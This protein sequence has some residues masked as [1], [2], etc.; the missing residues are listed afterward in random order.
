MTQPELTVILTHEHTDFDALASLLAASLLFPGALPVLPGQ[1]N[2]NVR[3]FLA[4]YKNQFPFYQAKELP[5]VAINHLIV[6]DTRSANLPKGVRNDA[7]WLVIDHHRTAPA[8][9]EARSATAHSEL[10]HAAVGANTT[11]L[12]EKLVEQHIDLTPAQVTLLALGIH[13]DTGSLTY[14]A[15]THRDG[16]ALAWLMEPERGLNLEV[17]RQF[18]RHPLSEAQRALLETLIDQSEFFEMAGH[19]VVIASAQAPDFT[20]EL[21]TLAHRLRDIHE[22][23]AIFLVVGLGEMVQVVA[24]STTDGLDVG[25]I[26]RGLGGGGHARAAAAPVHHADLEAVRNQISALLATHSQPAVTVRHIMT[27]GRP[28]LFSPELTIHEAYELMRRYGHEGYPVVAQTVEGGE[29]LLGVITRREVD[30]AMNHGLTERRVRS[31]M[32]PG[33]ITVRAYDSIAILRKTMIESGWG[34]VPVVDEAGKIIGIVTRTDLIKLWDEHTPPERHASEIDQRLRATLSSAQIALLKL[35]GQEVDQMDF[36]VY[37]VGGFVRD[38]LLNGAN[39]RNGALDIDIVIE[40]DAAAFA[41]RMQ[42]R[43]GGR[44]VIHKRFG[45]AKWLLNDP[46][47]PVDWRTLCAA[48]VLEDGA[49]QIASQLPAHLDFVTART[50]FYTAPTVL[51][52]VELSNIKLDL[53]RRDFTINTLACCLNPD[54]WGE[55]LDFYGGLPDLRNGLVRVLHSLSFVDDPTRIL[56][57]VRYEQRFGFQIEARTE[58][59][60]QD[61][62]ELLERVTPARIRH[63][64]E[65]ILQEAAPERVLQR[66]AQLGGLA[67]IHPALRVDEWVNVQFSRLRT[68]LEQPTANPSL[69]QAPLDLLYWGLLTLRLPSQAHTDLTVRLGLRGETQQVMSGLQRLQENLPRLDDPHLPPSQ[70]V[71]ILDK[72]VPVAQA[73]FLLTDPAPLVAERI[74]RYAAVWQTIRPQLT[75]A[76]LQALGLPPGPLYSTILSALRTARLDGQIS[77]REQ[78][79]ALTQQMAQAAR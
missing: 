21:S 70:L 13:E 71:D 52:T 1:L 20:D 19:R 78:E 15:T 76:D 17:L 69:R 43:Y 62:V 51:P 29:Q 72:V 56:R 55:L 38:L 67:Q 66:L 54:R 53:H 65:R 44:V 11:L 22:A 8:L 57:A 31:L 49:A 63:E 45:T 61:A 39:A 12:V 74:R 26:A 73:L 48:L 60:L 41:Q 27:I 46:A 47:L 59:L 64:I 35:I 25:A 28:Q 77:T 34:Q 14:A 68:A 3:D 75:G 18:L 4:L 36:A 79:I 23:D 58:E 30:R 2:R 6:V 10:W 32:Q 33:Q 16:R 40:G 42:M 7:A 5:R 9:A 24:R 37:L 50:E